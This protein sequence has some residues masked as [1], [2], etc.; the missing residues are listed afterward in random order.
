MI[1]KYCLFFFPPWQ[2]SI[3]NFNPIS[4]MCRRLN[5]EA[6]G[7]CVWMSKDASCHEFKTWWGRL[8]AKVENQGKISEGSRSRGVYCLIPLTKEAQHI[9]IWQPFF[10]H[11]RLKLDRR[12]RRKCHILNSDHHEYCHWGLWRQRS[13]KW[14]RLWVLALLQLW[15]EMVCTSFWVSCCRICVSLLV[16]SHSTA[17]MLWY[18]TVLF[19]AMCWK[20]R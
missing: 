12:K 13:N 14:S 8:E 6:L 10:F 3:A 19:Q 1:G 11:Q 18:G 17:Y 15:R 7:F 9:V 4:S 2:S 20:S 5:A 16:Q